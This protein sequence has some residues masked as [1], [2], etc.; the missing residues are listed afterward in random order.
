MAKILLGKVGTD[1]HDTGL[2]VVSRWL[3]DAGHEVVYA[4]LYNTPRGLVAMAVQEDPD[5]IGLSFH[6]GEPVYLSGRVLEQLRQ[7]GLDGVAVVVGGVVTPEM[8][9][10]LEALGVDALFTPGTARQAIV[11][12]VADVLAARRG[13]AP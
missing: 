8:A 6:G 9:D 5:L 7:A 10:E 4:G 13:A 1:A 11:D 12:T 3:M 2:T